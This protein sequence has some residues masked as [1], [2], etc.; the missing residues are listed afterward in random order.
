M[1][2]KDIHLKGYTSMTRNPDLAVEHASTN[3][4]EKIGEIPVLLHINFKCST[5]SNHFRLNSP[6][7]TPYPDEYEVLVDDGVNMIVLNVDQAF[8]Y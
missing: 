4:N 2:E 3:L 7:F 8:R 6:A 5:S 1:K